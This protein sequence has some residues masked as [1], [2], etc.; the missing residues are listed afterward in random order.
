[1]RVP[2]QCG[3]GLLVAPGVSTR[4]L[5]FACARVSR[6]T[7]DACMGDGAGKPT[8]ATVAV[9]V[10]CRDDGEYVSILPSLFAQP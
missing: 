10:D 1:M 4:S 6:A 3:A 7:G 9:Q 8:C 2:G 5:A